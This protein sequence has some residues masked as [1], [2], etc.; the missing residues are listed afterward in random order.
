MHLFHSSMSKN[1]ICFRG[2]SK[3]MDTALAFILYMSK[4]HA[5]KKKKEKNLDM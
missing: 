1:L 5:K 4:Y 3:K 2:K